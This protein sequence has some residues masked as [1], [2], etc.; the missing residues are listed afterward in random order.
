MIVASIYMLWAFQ[1]AFHGKPKGVVAQ[2]AGAAAGPGA[3]KG[4]VGDLSM[5]ERA[6]IIPLLLVIAFLGVYP[7]PVLNRITPSVQALIS[8]VE[9]NSSYVE[10]AVAR[11]GP[12]GVAHAVTHPP[13]LVLQPAHLTSR[14]ARKRK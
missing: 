14:R 12:A 11:V 2:P 1:Q 4:I 13:A 7:A 8:H 3:L 5:G 10:P 6:L 9:A